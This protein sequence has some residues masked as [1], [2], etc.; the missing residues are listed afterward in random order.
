MRKTAKPRRLTGIHRDSST[1][2]QGKTW[3]EPEEWTYPSGGFNRRAYVRCPDGKYRV[4]RSSIPDTY[5]TI[6][7][8]LVFKKKHVSGYISTDEKHPD[9]EFVFVA[10]G[11]HSDI[12]S[13]SFSD[14]GGSPEKSQ[15]LQ[16]RVVDGNQNLL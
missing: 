8:H 11:K 12:F 3:L 1:I 5:F 16:S 6:P 9:K 13:A 14:L 15:V 4:V 2:Y 10:G 7:A